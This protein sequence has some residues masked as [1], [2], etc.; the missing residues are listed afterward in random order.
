MGGNGKSL[1]LGPSKS[2]LFHFRF[3]LFPLRRQVPNFSSYEVE[4][5]NSLNRKSKRKQ[6]GKIDSLRCLFDSIHQSI[7]MTINQSIRTML[8][9]LASPF[10]NHYHHH[11][12]HHHHHHH[13][14]QHYPCLSPSSFLLFP[15]S[16]PFGISRHKLFPL[17]F[18]FFSL[19]K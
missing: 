9:S 12:H 10:L 6:G 8:H 16:L 11:Y 4:I 19:V 5:L 17:S 2:K 13:P 1:H 15:Y 7:T 3:F 14:Y 18:M